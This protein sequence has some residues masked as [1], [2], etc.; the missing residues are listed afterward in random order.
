MTKSTAILGRVNGK[1]VMT[2]AP[3]GDFVDALDLAISAWS[4]SRNMVVQ[5]MD[6]ELR[7]YYRALGQHDPDFARL[8]EGVAADGDDEG[9][10]PTAADLEWHAAWVEMIG[11]FD[12]DEEGGEFEVFDDSPFEIAV[13]F[14]L[15][16][17]S[18]ELFEA[19]ESDRLVRS[20]GWGRGMRIGAEEEAAMYHGYRGR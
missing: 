4:A 2:L 1:A 19:R 3:G 5:A 20:Y 11:E 12:A 17:R 16:W 6:A 10:A 9:D 7:A 8:A 18:R 15:D 13:D 14:D